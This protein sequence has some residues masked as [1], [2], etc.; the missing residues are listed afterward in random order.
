MYYCVV[1]SVSY[2]VFS[3]MW[4]EALRTFSV[5]LA[6]ALFCIC[7]CFFVAIIVV[8]P[9]RFVGSVIRVYET[10]H[11]GGEGLKFVS[12]FSNSETLGQF[13]KYVSFFFLRETFAQ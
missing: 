9:V 5:M 7:F 4:S 10:C 12:F 3:F 1:P 6:Q 13:L 11:F 8:F 2:V